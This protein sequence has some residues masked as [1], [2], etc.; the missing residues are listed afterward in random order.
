M[1]ERFLGKGYNV[2]DGYMG[3]VPEK[4]KYVLFASE[5]DYRECVIFPALESEEDDED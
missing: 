1:A 5:E 4:G 3:W 2:P